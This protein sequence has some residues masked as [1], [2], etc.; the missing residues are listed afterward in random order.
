MKKKQVTKVEYIQDEFARL[1]DESTRQFVRD[2]LMM[3]QYNGIIVPEKCL[4]NYPAAVAFVH[5]TYLA[6]KAGGKT[7]LSAGFR[8]R[9]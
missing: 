4:R 3:F 8:V 1:A 5:K 9:K 7:I 6:L 2:A